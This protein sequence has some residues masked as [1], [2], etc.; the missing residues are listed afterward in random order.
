MGYSRTASSQ[1][2]GEIEIKDTGIGIREKSRLISRNYNRS[3]IKHADYGG[4]ARSI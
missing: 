2:R 4:M 1:Q 3:T